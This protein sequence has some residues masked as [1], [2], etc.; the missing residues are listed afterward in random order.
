M[1]SA[2]QPLTADQYATAITADSYTSVA[3]TQHLPQQQIYETYPGYEYA[4]AAAAAAAAGYTQA[5]AGY[6]QAAAEYSQTAYYTGG[7]DA[8]QYVTT[9]ATLAQYYSQF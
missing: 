3:G 6:S 5:A 8:T 7:G 4:D 9:D 1:Q 2:N